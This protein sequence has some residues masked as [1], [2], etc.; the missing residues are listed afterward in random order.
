MCK[1]LYERGNPLI[2]ET[3]PQKIQEAQDQ[4]SAIVTLTRIGL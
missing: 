3:W 1:E 4:M 2:G